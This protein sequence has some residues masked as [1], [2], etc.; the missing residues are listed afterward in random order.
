MKFSLFK[1]TSDIDDV[2]VYE[3]SLLLKICVFWSPCV[4]AIF[5]WFIW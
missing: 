3:C 5:Y 4:F 1:I 2:L